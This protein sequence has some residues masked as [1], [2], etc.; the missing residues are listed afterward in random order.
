VAVGRE[1]PD[2][3]ACPERDPQTTVLVDRDAVGGPARGD[4]H[5][6]RRSIAAIGRAV[7]R[8]YLPALI[9]ASIEDMAVG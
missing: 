4:N 5:D 9:V 6:V 8:E 7:D 1:P 2:T 3:G